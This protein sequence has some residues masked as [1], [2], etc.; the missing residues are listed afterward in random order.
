[1]VAGDESGI[2]SNPD[3]LEMMALAKQ[4]KIDLEAGRVKV[5]DSGLEK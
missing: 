4:L 3:Y 1:M 5:D 2:E